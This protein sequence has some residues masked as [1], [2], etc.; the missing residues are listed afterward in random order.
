MQRIKRNEN[1]LLLILFWTFIFE[2]KRKRK[3][4]EDMRKK[5]WLRNKKKH[6]RLL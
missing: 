3:S 1:L 4:L 5:K 6:N 2:T